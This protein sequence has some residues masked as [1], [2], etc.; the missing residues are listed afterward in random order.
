MRVRSAADWSPVQ[1]RG[2]LWPR[3]SQTQ[4]YQKLG[5][6]K[7]SRADTYMAASDN[8]MENNSKISVAVGVYQRRHALTYSVGV[9]TAGVICT[10][11]RLVD[12]PRPVIG[13]QSCRRRTRGTQV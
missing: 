6:A 5:L 4:S 10:A 13:R 1:N 2:Q 3:L 12:H 7:Q 11:C 9:Q 8:K